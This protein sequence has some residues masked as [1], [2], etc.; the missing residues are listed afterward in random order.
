MDYDS[1][2]ILQFKKSSKELTMNYVSD[3]NKN[4]SI[5]DNQNPHPDLIKSL[6]NFGPVLAKQ[7]WIDDLNKEHFVCTGFTVGSKGESYFVILSGKVETANGHIVG[8]SSGQLVLENNTK[9]PFNKMLE[10]VKKE[11]FEYFFK[12]KT[13][14]GKLDFK[15]KEEE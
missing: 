10:T 1:V 7:F 6:E 11:A 5:S 2:E 14:Q 9:D 13:A 3:D 15:P 8:I 12:D 4:C